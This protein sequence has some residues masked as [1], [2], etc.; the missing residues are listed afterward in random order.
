M[1][2][3]PSN[4]QLADPP[5]EDRDRAATN[6]VPGDNPLHWEL[7]RQD[8]AV[9]DPLLRSLETLTQLLDRPTS[10]Q[11]LS[12]GLP[13]RD[14]MMSTDLCGRALERAG[15][16]SRIVR[17][18]LK[19]IDSLS[20]PC[21]L[22]LENRQTC[23][24]VKAESADHYTVILPE[25]GRG[26]LE[27]KSDELNRRYSGY[28]LFARPEVGR[29]HLDR[30]QARP[31]KGHW[32][33]STLLKQWPAYIEVL[34]AAV[35]INSFA[36]ASPLFVM[37]VYDRV[38]PNNAHETLWVLAI[39]AA[40]VFG[41][42]FLL[43]VLRGYFIDSAGKI[44]DIRLASSIFEH[45][46]GI[47]QASKP[48]SAGAFANHLREFESLR[49]FFTSATV[50]TLVDLPFIFFFIGIVW[51]I[52]GPIAYVPAIAVP[53]VITIGILMQIPLDKVIKQTFK[54]A[55]AKHGLLVEAINGLE[56]I[57]S[58]GAEGRTQRGWE[59]YVA[60]TA[61]SSNKAR[62][63]SSITVN[64]AALAANVVTIGVVIVGVYQITAG[65][66]TVGALVACTIISGR[67]M[68]PLGQVAGLLTRYYQAK[69]SLQT[70]NRVMAMDL[71]RPATT[72]F[73]HRPEL[74]GAIEF[75][76]VSMT[77]PGQKLPAIA[78]MSFRIQPGE[79]VGLVGRIGSGKTT[80][81]K[82]MLGLYTPQQGALLFDGTDSRQLDPADLRSNI[83]CVPQ[84]VFLFQ[85]TI[86]ENITLG[87]P[88]VDDEAV[89]RAAALSGVEDF[90]SRHP[91]GYDMNVGERGEFLSGGQRQSIA[92]A[93]AML[94]NPPIFL[95][96]E[97]TSAMDNSAENRFKA[98]MDKYLDDR[99]LILVTHRTSLL[100]LVN[101]LLVLDGGKLVADGARD[102][103]LKALAGG[104]IR[105]AR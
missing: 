102:Q 23:V 101:R 6:H 83:G 81:E 16:S 54:E 84:D 99:T 91:M 31:A 64:T 53:I 55:A 90:V 5:A 40:T 92:L 44:T 38:V 105:G 10:A 48:A 93:R 68:A 14:G 85:G 94:L 46:L 69:T 28:V 82:L 25:T 88:H 47:R 74:K 77:Y 26:T 43:K 70:L 79:R 62:F 22:L 56:T 45:V 8:Q 76:N 58:V 11:A 39:G 61:L 18:R 1:D 72:R 67:A 78:D 21:I 7:A 3:G 4:Q 17:R 104:Q 2:N 29:E 37:N 66:M 51:L 63:F 12:A 97:P 75:K 59:H 87:A 42:D 100:S 52:G 49:D 98:T 86:R 65:E 41:F 34:I 35:M 50:T 32:F 89:L 80:I 13:L 20:T 95:F 71:E 73:L 57:K 60:A 96:D 36:L 19:D 15:L 24:L 33:W 27:I 30:D 103:V 9:D